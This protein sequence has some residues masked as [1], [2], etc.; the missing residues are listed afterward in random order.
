MQ[1][2]KRELPKDYPA[3]KGHQP[4]VD[5]W[6]ANA[7]PEKSRRVGQLWKEQ[8]RLFPD[9]KNRGKSFIRILDYVRTNG[10]KPKAPK[11]QGNT[12]PH[13]KKQ[14]KAEIRRELGK[15]AGKTGSVSGLV[16]DPSGKAMGGVMVSA[17]D[18]GRRMTTRVL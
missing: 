16:K 2:A 15:P 8:E 7:P 9:M 3:G 13:I 18:K 1:I 4:F 12:N 14:G 6:F 5:K 17:F 11:Q 10:G